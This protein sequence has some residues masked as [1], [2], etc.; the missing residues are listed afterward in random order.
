MNLPEYV[1]L[2]AAAARM[3]ISVRVLVGQL[4]AD[5]VT[6]H[7]FSPRH[8]AVSKDDFDNWIARR[9]E[10]PLSS[11][12]PEEKV[13]RQPDAGRRRKRPA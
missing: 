13:I 6:V 5:G 8:R 9:A 4:L 3:G 1:P 7:R 11:G 12:A 2:R 10:R